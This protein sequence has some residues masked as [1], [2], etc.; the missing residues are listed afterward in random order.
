MTTSSSMRVKPLRRMGCSFDSL[1]R[2]HTEPL[3][4]VVFAT[5]EITKSNQ[6]PIGTGGLND[7]FR[8]EL[9]G[10]EYEGSTRPRHWWGADLRRA[11]FSLRPDAANPADQK[12][13][14]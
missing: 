14:T 12:A 8:P 3:R 4:P 10:V 1:Q 2:V 7:S 5:H 9:L 13:S 11:T 6:S